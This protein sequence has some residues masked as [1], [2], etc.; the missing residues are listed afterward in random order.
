MGTKSKAN[1]ARLANLSKRNPG[2]QKATVEDASD[3]DDSDWI[4]M[5]E[6]DEISDSE[7][8]DSDD[9]NDAEN[10]P[11][12]PRGEKYLFHVVDYDSGDE[13]DL[14]EEGTE[15]DDEAEIENEAALLN[16][17]AALSKAQEIATS[18]ARSKEQGAKRPKHYTHNSKRSERRHKCT[19]K[20]LV[21]VGQSLIE[22]WCTKP[23]KVV[24]DEPLSEPE[25]IEL[26]PST[27]VSNIDSASISIH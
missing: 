23:R 13:S 2:S 10:T 22:L 25:V 20:D 14:D 16:F 15:G 26:P 5:P 6:M 27:M 11:R 7:A 1:Q 21:A 17:S 19:R 9:E 12:E 3:S 4:P 24:P 8:E 18:S